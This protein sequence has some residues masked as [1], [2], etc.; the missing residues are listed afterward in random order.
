MEVITYQGR[1]QHKK[2]FEILGNEEIQQKTAPRK[3]SKYIHSMT[4]VI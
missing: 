1:G 2:K 4:Y 3:N